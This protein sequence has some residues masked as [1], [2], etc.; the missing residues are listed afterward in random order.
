[1]RIRYGQTVRGRRGGTYGDKHRRESLIE[2]RRKKRNKEG[3][4]RCVVCPGT[5][6]T[7]SLWIS[8]GDRSDGTTK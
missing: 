4:K 7:N 2:R 6:L 5:L 8:F 3:R 1:M